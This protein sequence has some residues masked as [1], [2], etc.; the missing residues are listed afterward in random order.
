M[1]YRHAYHAG[2]FADV[3]KHLLL[4]R[5]VEYLKLKAQPFRVID[6]HAGA[7]LYNLA[8]PEADR[9]R[10]WEAGVGRVLAHGLHP[11]AAG[12]ARPWLD[13]LARLNDGPQLRRYPGSPVLVRTLLRPRDRLTAIELHPADLAAL[14]AQF[15]GDIKTRVIGLDGWLA[16]GAHVP[17]KERRGMV[18]VDPPFEAPDEF[19][20]LLDGLKRAYRRWPQG[21]YALWY[22]V[23]EERSVA[24][25]RLQLRQSGIADMMDI[26][27]SLGQPAMEGKLAA[28]GMIIVNPPYVLGDELRILLP[29]L[30]QALRPDGGGEWRLERLTP[31]QLRA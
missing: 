18:L 19:A 29:A 4:T 15:A 5:I 26:R 21:T 12:L 2:N 27:F 22:P 25:F 14:R 7:G 16:L 24:A 9:T 13:L 23:K 31:E 17:P 1:N 8:G 11:Q 20:R 3:F 6:T 28:C 30:L 10:E